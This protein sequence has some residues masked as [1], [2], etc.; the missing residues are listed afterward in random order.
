MHDHT[1][2][3][4]VE[5][6]SGPRRSWKQWTGAM[7]RDLV[8][9][10]ARKPIKLPEKRLPIPHSSDVRMIVWAFA[11]TDL[12]T[13]FV[14]DA[15]L[16]PAGRTIHLLWMVFSLVGSLGFCAMTARSPHLLDRR[17]LRLR[18]GPFRDLTIPAEAIGSVRVAHGSTHG[19]GLRRVPDEDGAVACTVGS[20][21]NFVIDLEEPL[22]VRLRKGQP[23]LARRIYAA[24]DQPGEAARLISRSIAGGAKP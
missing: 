7:L 18:T 11:G 21:T 24:A 6:D 14:I 23:V 22:L 4:S 10:L 17:S 9:W 15:M 16:P 3:E 19:Y 8:D 20:A 12:V 1:T 13:G 5:A 2:P